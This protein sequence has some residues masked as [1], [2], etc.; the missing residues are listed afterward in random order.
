MYMYMYKW[1]WFVLE[2]SGA[3]NRSLFITTAILCPRKLEGCFY[4]RTTFCL[5]IRRR[6]LRGAVTNPVQLDA[7]L[8]IPGVGFWM[9][10]AK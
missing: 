3:H 4:T 2:F 7:H 9:P 6:D 8:P 10:A 1:S 5:L